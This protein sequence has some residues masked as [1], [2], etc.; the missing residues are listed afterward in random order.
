MIRRGLR[1]LFAEQHDVLVIGE[2]ATADAAMAGARALRPDVAIVPIRLGGRPAG[3]ELCRSLAQVSAARTILYTAFTGPADVQ[4]AIVAGVDGLVSKLADGA[5]LVRC[6]R[7][8][9]AGQRTWI[10]DGAVPAGDAEAWPAARHLTAREGEILDL[11]LRRYPNRRIAAALRIE[12]S[13]VKTHVR[14]VLRK[15]GVP[16]RQALFDA[17]SG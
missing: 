1:D 2:A 11:I 16:S 12:V 6:V 8:V 5:E 17:R 10:L 13:T 14:N 4:A 3:I 9:V 15:L 7:A